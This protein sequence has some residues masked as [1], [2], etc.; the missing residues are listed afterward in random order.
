[1]NGEGYSKMTQIVK[2]VVKAVL[3]EEKKLI[4]VCIV[5]LIQTLKADPEMVKLIHKISHANDGQHHKD[6]NNIT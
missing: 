4:S 3:A 6:N 5:A 2:E 1:L